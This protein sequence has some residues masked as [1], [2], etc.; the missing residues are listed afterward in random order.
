MRHSFFAKNK[1]L[2]DLHDPAESA[3]ND[4]GIAGLSELYS[5]EDSNEPRVRDEADIMLETGNL[6]ELQTTFSIYF[7]RN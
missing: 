4:D 5:P 1:G 3:Y 6:A 2:S 7:Y